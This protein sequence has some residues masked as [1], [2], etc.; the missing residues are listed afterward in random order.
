M[1]S[2]P[3]DPGESYTNKI[4]M[5]NKG[6]KNYIN[7]CVECIWGCGGGGEGIR[8]VLL[9]KVYLHESSPMSKKSWGRSEE[10]EQ[11]KPHSS[12]YRREEVRKSSKGRAGN[13]K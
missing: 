2:F 3:V 5:C 8:E 4:Y 7:L 12:M 13:F 11:C 6:Q 9:E 1:S 10:V